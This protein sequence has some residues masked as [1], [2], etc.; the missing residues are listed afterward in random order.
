M[1]RF[2]VVAIA[3]AATLA[4][5]G[6]AGAATVR[7]TVVHRNAHAHKLVVATRTGRLVAVRTSR[8]I[9]VGRVVSV[10]GARIRTVGRAR[11]A[12]LRGTVTYVNRARRVFT[13]SSR[14]AS[15]LVRRRSV[16]AARA[17][18]DD[19][20]ATGSQVAVDAN[21]D[22][23]GDVDADKVD[24]QGQDDNGI[25]LEGKVLSVDTN[26]RTLSLSAD[27]DEESGAAIVVHVPA[28]VDLSQFA[29][30]NDVELVVSKESDGSFTL[31]KVDEND[32]EG[33]D[34]DN[35]GDNHHN[36]DEQ[37]NG[38]DAGGGGDD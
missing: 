11:H 36:G 25:D 26:A 16:H 8:A 20:P 9:R 31:Q 6:P 24:E 38:G 14:G 35:G 22:D 28:G 13:L 12:R 34:Q 37:D 4:L 29:V 33:D 1:R 15:V 17:A 23:Q 19:M 32:N 7:G 27:D 30:G 10:R 5:A 18:S 2:L 21:L 3:A